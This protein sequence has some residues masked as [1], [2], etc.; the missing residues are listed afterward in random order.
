MRG[1]GLILVI[2]Y[3]IGPVVAVAAPAQIV[4]VRHG[5]KPAD[6]SIFLSQQG[7]LRAYSLPKFFLNNPMVNQFGTPVAVFA[8][9]AKDDTSGDP[10][11]SVRPIETIAPTAQVLGLK[12][13]D[14]AKR[15]E[16]SKIVSA[17]MNNS[18]YDGKTVLLAWEHKAIPKLVGAFGFN[19]GHGNGSWPGD[20]Y[21]QAWVLRPADMS[22]A[23]I[24][25]K[26]LPTDNPNG[27]LDRWKD[28]PS[29]EIPPDFIAQFPQ[30]A[31]DDA[32]EALMGK[33]TDPPV[34]LGH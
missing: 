30:C 7:C 19:V 14:P 32:L 12:V 28:G 8:M 16:F 10:D 21:D 24:P 34:D 26:A 11:S 3:L 6:D 5:E 23:I 9:A 2:G 1:A 27:G 4:I 25:E 33:I 17:V 15:L 31:N 22:I 18:A 29:G 20:I 13:E